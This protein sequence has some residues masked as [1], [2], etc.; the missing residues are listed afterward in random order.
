MS[1]PRQNGSARLFTLWARNNLWANYRL[2]TACAALSEADL[3]AP[4][5]GFFPSLLATLNHILIVDWFYVDALEGGTL[6]HG[7]FVSEVPCPVLAD[8]VREQRAVDGR[9]VRFC[10]NLTEADMSRPVTVHRGDRRQVE[11]TDA[12]LMHMFQ[13]QIHH[14]GQAHAM[15]AGTGVRPPQ[16]DEFFSVMDA[17]VRAADLAA[18]GLT[19]ADTRP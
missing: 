2:L 6:G 19:E 7:A 18:L 5:T 9:L 16:L 12:L 8:L 1:A 13:H 3:T 10:E 4:R 15:L 17:P 14:R 11:R